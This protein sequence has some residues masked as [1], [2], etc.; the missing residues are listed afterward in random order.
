MNYEPCLWAFRRAGMWLVCDR[1]P[2]HDGRH[3]DLHMDADW[4]TGDG[5]DVIVRLRTVAPP[6]CSQPD[7]SRPLHCRDLCHRHYNR[8]RET[9]D[10]N[11]P[12]R[13][14][15]RMYDADD[16]LFLINC[17]ESVEHA[18]SRVGWNA[19]AAYRWAL[20]HDHQQLRDAVA[21][22]EQTRRQARKKT[23]A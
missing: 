7:C 9:G 21:K 19:A 20:H 10:P 1:A 22:A 6:L 4:W 15:K 17:G 12:T 5:M 18:L 11:T 3:Y 16:I 14:E 23:T 13:T 8:M 2:G